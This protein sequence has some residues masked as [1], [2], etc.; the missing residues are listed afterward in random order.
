MTLITRVSWF[1]LIALG[2]ILVGYSGL[3]YGLSRYYLYREFDQRIHAALN[4]LVAA[5]E[6]ESDDVKWEPS[7]HTVTLGS[8]HDRD[9]ARWVVV[10]EQG[11]SSI[12][13][14]T[15]RKQ[16]IEPRYS[17]M[18]VSRHRHKTSR[19]SAATGGS[20]RPAWRQSPPSR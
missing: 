5:V 12:N 6:V 14:R 4:T 2:G 16:R 13:P 18:L 19:K 9:D 11:L 10:N 3:L 8:E 20:C 1:F 7:D 17:N 15:C